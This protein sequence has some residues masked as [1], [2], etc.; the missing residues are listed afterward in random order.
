MATCPRSPFTP[1]FIRFGALVASIG[2]AACAVESEVD[3]ALAIDVEDLAPADEATFDGRMPIVLADEPV[4]EAPVRARDFDGNDDAELLSFVA[5]LPGTVRWQEVRD[6][7]SRQEALQRLALDRGDPEEDFSYV[8]MV[9]PQGHYLV[10][11]EREAVT[12]VRE[13][14]EMVA[15]GGIAG[16]D[17]VEPLP[18]DDEELDF[19]GWSNGYDS[20][21]RLTGNSI[22]D[23]VGRVSAWGG[24]CSGAL[25]GRRLVR[26]AAHCVIL[27][28][29]WG[30]TAAG[31][32]TF[33]YR[34]D[35]GS[36]PVSVS[37]SSYFYG[38]NYL[39]S[40]CGQSL[41][42]D[43]GFGYRNNFGACTWADWAILIL[44]SNWNG[45]TWHSWFGYKGLVG[46][47]I[48]MELQSGGYPGCGLPESPSGCVNQ[49][50]Y[51]DTS[52]P[53]AVSAWTSGTSKFRSGCDVSPGN[54][55]GPVW[56]EGTA[57]LI[58]HAQWQDCGTCPA[59]ST[60][61]SAPNHYLGHDGWLFN[62]QNSLRNSY[63]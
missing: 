6:S 14:L 35:A 46:G 32:V 41:G 18:A 4:T 37:T 50:Y 42:A 47:D 57:Y 17:H 56:E 15:D 30:G 45:N 60:N 34:R 55:G 28:T 61:R 12:V 62:F 20:R 63:P 40:N 58:G 19:R 26:T 44:P 1:S 52:Y 31:S 9:T 8:G 23:K 33:D 25:I 49:A 51:R 39:P 21:V 36:V 10:E 59:G 48:N 7:E 27:H 11:V 24:Q 3:P 13:Q 16:P 54:S 43:S 2:L 5:G 38:G 22:P 29:A 53:C